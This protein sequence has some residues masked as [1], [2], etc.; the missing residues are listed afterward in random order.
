MLNKILFIILVIAIQQ[1][2][3]S[4]I[5]TSGD[6]QNNSG[7]LKLSNN[8]TY[9]GEFKNGNFHYLGALIC[10]DTVFSGIWVNGTLNEKKIIIQDNFIYFGKTKD[11]LPYGEGMFFYS[12][13]TYAWSDLWKTKYNSVNNETIIFGS[14]EITYDK[15][16]KEFY[17]GEIVNGQPNGI[18]VNFINND[19]L[20]GFY[21]DGELIGGI[22][23]EI[24]EIYYLTDDQGYKYFC[25]T[26]KNEYCYYL[27]DKNGKVWMKEILA[28]KK[29]KNKKTGKIQA[30]KGGQILHLF[31]INC[32]NNT[33]DV[34][35]K[36]N[37]DNKKNILN[38]QYPNDFGMYIVPGT[39]IE[40]LKNIIC[41]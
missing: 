33:F 1:N 32:A 35:M 24:N 13:G 16:K 11:L 3:L 23:K 41:N 17:M 31:N 36:I 25:T 8:V 26:E 12:D 4:Q 9:K 21:K 40:S 10:P 14:G 15:S 18:G 19:I 30:I 6:C 34:F 37:Y 29:I 27:I 2:T 28:T 39:I 20:E 5:C 22:N 7:I 38:T